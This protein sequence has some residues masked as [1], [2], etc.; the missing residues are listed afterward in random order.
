MKINHS[1]IYLEDVSFYA[2]HGV[3]PQEW[4]IGNNYIIN[5][6]LSVNLRDAIESDNVDD[7]VNYASVYQVLA[8]EMAVPSNLLEHVCGRIVERLFRDFNTINDIQIKLSKRNP[9]MGADI[10]AA[11]VE[12]NCS[13]LDF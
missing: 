1:Y 6:R 12:I 10:A 2:Y 5:L 9:P 13:R 11:S 3:A 4:V 7:T 8:E